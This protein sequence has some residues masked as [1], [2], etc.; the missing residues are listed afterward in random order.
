M[1]YYSDGYIQVNY[2][3]DNS[4]LT[5][6][7]L[8]IT[9]NEPT[10]NLGHT[11]QVNII[12]L[13]I[14]ALEPNFSFVAEVL[15][16]EITLHS[17]IA[18][19]NTTS[20]ADSLLLT[21]NINT[22]TPTGQPVL[23]GG[24]PLI[25]ITQLEPLLIV[26]PTFADNNQLLLSVLT[27][28]ILLDENNILVTPNSLLLKL[29]VYCGKMENFNSSR[30]LDILGDGSC[31]AILP[32]DNDISE[33]IGDLTLFNYS[34]TALS[35]DS[36]GLF[37]T[38]NLLA[39]DADR[40]HVH[41]ADENLSPPLHVTCHFNPLDSTNGIVMFSGY[42]E[43][44]TV[45]D[46][47]IIIEDGKFQIATVEY[48]LVR[49][50]TLFDTGVLATVGSYFF[51]SVFYTINT[52]TF[53]IDDTPYFVNTPYFANT[54][55]DLLDISATNWSPLDEVLIKGTLSYKLEQGRI[56]TR[57]L[58]SSELLTVKSEIIFSCPTFSP[59]IWVQESLLLSI[60]SNEPIVV[61]HYGSLVQPNI[62]T[63]SITP[64]LFNYSGGLGGAVIIPPTFQA[65]SLYILISVMYI[66]QKED[67]FIQAQRLTLSLTTLQINL[68]TT[69]HP[70]PLHVP[71]N[72]T[73]SVAQPF[74]DKRVSSINGI[75]FSNALYWSQNKFVDE[76]IS[77]LSNAVDGSNIISVF[78]LRK[79]SKNHI[80][81]THKSMV[82]HKTVVDNLT[83]LVNTDS[84]VIIFTDGSYEDMIFDLLNNPFEIEPTYEGSD[85]YYVDMKVLI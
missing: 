40:N 33:I 6:I 21:S 84:Y 57:E 80:I 19:V 76:Y 47:L 61:G 49:T 51:I 69:V 74:R 82:L 67:T 10:I 36:N 63:L 35:I 58:N 32:F 16:L 50:I 3:D 85:Y 23:D 41:Y 75:E 20:L 11:Q 62:L 78:P 64:F 66:N 65:Q 30:L 81:S 17:H 29:H 60:S 55:N 34:T 71:I 44:K 68:S 14:I 48:D 8:Q 70:T 38:P 22:A 79:Y 59:I 31:K 24:F 37:G 56:F 53:Y 9:V 52:L 12:D 45:F 39:S 27:P 28:N 26:Q 72:I 25:A 18:F 7:P 13:S 15:Q 5:P 43:G 54:D 73:S 46:W 77:E 83:S 4:F 2:Y 42:G 1:S